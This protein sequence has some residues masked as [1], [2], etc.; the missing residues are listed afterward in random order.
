MNLNA[1]VNGFGTAKFDP[2]QMANILGFSHMAEKYRVAYDNEKED[3]F[4][5][6]T[7]HGIV[8]FRRD[9]CLYTS[10]LSKN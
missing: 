6:H 8:K 4:L 5:I 1:D 7:E 2:D 9:G 10:K 3:A